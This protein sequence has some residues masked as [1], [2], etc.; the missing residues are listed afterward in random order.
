MKLEKTNECQSFDV[1]GI[2]IKVNR[3]WNKSLALLYFLLLQARPSQLLVEKV[4]EV[5]HAKNMDVRFLIPVLSGLSKQEVTAALTKLIK[6]TPAVVKEVRFFLSHP[7][8]SS[9]GN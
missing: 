3:Y 1:R 4:R 2:C 7:L 8:Y 5:Y 6:L 9:P